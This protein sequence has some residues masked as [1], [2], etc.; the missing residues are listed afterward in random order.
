M[1]CRVPVH[2]GP[3]AESTES[4]LLCTKLNY[5]SFEHHL[6]FFGLV[7]DGDFRLLTLLTAQ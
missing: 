7:A 4:P 2:V 6:T 5:R 1:S 3:R